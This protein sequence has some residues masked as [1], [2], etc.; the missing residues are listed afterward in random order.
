MERQQFIVN[1]NPTCLTHLLQFLC[2]TEVAE[3]IIS[4]LIFLL[5]ISFD[6]RYLLLVRVHLDCVRTRENNF[7]RCMRSVR[8]LC[9]CKVY[10]R[11]A[12]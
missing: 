10:E 6:Y 3:Y 2:V 8:S 5:V 1:Y 9:I 4:N 7:S 12:Q 11:N